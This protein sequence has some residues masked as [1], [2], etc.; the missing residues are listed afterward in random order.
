MSVGGY[1]VL[2]LLVLCILVQR[3]LSVTAGAGHLWRYGANVMDDPGKS[4][5]ADHPCDA[6]TSTGWDALTGFA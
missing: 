1:A 3:I 4:L 5:R 2:F 6:F